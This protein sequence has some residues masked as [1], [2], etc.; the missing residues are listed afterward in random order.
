[1]LLKEDQPK[2]RKENAMIPAPNYRWKCKD[3]GEELTVHQHEE[4]FQ[5]SAVSPKCPKCGGKMVGNPIVC[6]GPFP[7]NPFRKD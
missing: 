6:R 5:F 7:E 3:C 4:F 2:K 1:M